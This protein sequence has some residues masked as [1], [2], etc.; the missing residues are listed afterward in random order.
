M[1]RGFNHDGIGRTRVASAWAS[2]EVR[3]ARGKHKQ[4][5]FLI[6]RCFAANRLILMQLCRGGIPFGQTKPMT[7]FGAYA[8]NAEESQKF[9]KRLDTN[10]N[11]KLWSWEVV[12]KEK[13]RI[14]RAE[15]Y[16]RYIGD[17]TDAGDMKEVLHEM[18]EK[19]FP[20]CHDEG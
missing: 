11:T 16:S 9:C 18:N 12:D 4:K 20:G 8:A 3:I 13:L 14:E 17:K 15:F 10:E 5:R 2:E 7:T 1:S 6:N 19:D